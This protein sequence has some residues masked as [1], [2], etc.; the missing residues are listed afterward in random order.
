[1]RFMILHGYAFFFGKSG[2]NPF[3]EGN[4]MRKGFAVLL[5]AVL[6]AAFALPAAADH[7][8][9]GFYRAIGH[10]SNFKPGTNV[11]GIITPS[12]DN[13]DVTNA[14]VEQRLRMRY[15]FGTENVKAIA[16]F[17]I[18]MNW[19]DSA[20]ISGSRNAG[21]GLNADSINLETK[22]IYLWFKVPNT[23]TD[24]SVGLQNQTDAYAGVIFGG[25]DFTGVFVNSK[26]EPVALKLGWGKW[27][28]NNV[29]RADDIDIYVAEAKLVPMKD[30]SVGVNL[31]YINDMGNV[32]P[33]AGLPF[34]FPTTDNAFI[35]RIWTPGV[36][37]AAKAGPVALTG[38]GFYQFGTIEFDNPAN[39]DVDIR[40][41][42]AD[43]RGD[44]NLG[45]GKLF[46][47][48]IYVSGGDNNANKVESI[49]TADNFFQNQAFFF[50][51]DMMVL[52]K[53]GYDI[54]SAFG[55]VNSLGFGG[56]GCWHVA[57]GYSLK[58]MEKL[59]LKFG[60]GHAQ[61]SENLVADGPNVGKGIGTEVNAVATYNI[62]KGLDAGVAGAYVWLGDFFDPAPG[63]PDRV[64][65]YDLQARINYVW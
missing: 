7:E 23:S 60:A 36:N 41:F 63:Q 1:M 59:T 12:F 24:V 40:A 17:E 28:E 15:S 8:L 55:I 13:A 9:V 4:V 65:P 33:R 45:P 57:G 20:A 21:G 64:N 14:F 50:R 51:T 62:A 30:V 18:D 31:Y 44:V 37:F 47:E 22:N 3:K 56:R 53:N 61:A 34:G 52:L 39:P 25:A 58:P 26:F 16:F 2:S 42:A 27:F 29:G 43:L 19:G 5:A 38:F 54:N 48:G 6:V 10:V 35:Q 32:S 49:V 46:V 11:Q